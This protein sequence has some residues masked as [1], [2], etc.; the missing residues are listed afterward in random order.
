M[1]EPT[2]VASTPD[3]GLTV[4]Q[5]LANSYL[6]YL[7]AVIFGFVIDVLFPVQIPVK[8]F[9][10]LGLILI[11]LGTVV[12][13]WAQR[14]SGKSSAIRRSAKEDL[15]VHH[16]STGPY[17]V[18][19]IPTQYGLFFM[20]FGLGMIFYSL[21]MMIAVLVA[22]IIARYV[23]IPKEEAYLVKKYGQAYLDYKK[24]VRA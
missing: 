2:N 14:S 10:P 7:L 1:T 18:T 4:H 21:F 11:I 13:V 23:F 5:I 3:S 6:L 22:F 20:T 15:G 24:T 12:I 8:A 9:S 16:F 19:R 17:Y